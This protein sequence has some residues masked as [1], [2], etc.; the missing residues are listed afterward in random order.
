[1]F[2]VSSFSWTTGLFVQTMCLIDRHLQVFLA[3]SH[4]CIHSHRCI[5]LSLSPHIR[6]EYLSQAKCVRYLTYILVIIHTSDIPTISIRET[7]C[8]LAIVVW[9]S[10]SLIVCPRSAN[11]TSTSSFSRTII[12]RC[13]RTE[14]KEMNNRLPANNRP[15]DEMPEQEKQS[16]REKKKTTVIANHASM[17]YNNRT[18]FFSLWFFS[19]LFSSLLLLLRS[20]SF[21]LSVSLCHSYLQ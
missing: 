19:P 16:K 4:F 20:L 3:I 7:F 2:F 13:Y 11:R 17:M 8:S 9:P 10:L 1:M 18:P 5:S 12:W 15:I 6:I 14:R 21:C